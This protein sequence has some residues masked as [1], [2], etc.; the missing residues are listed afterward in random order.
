MSSKR[1]SERKDEQVMQ[2]Q[3]ATRVPQGFVFNTGVRAKKGVQRK[4]R[5]AATTAPSLSAPAFLTSKI[6][7]IRP[8]DKDIAGRFG[9]RLD[10]SYANVLACCKRFLKFVGTEFDFKPTAGL[11]L[12]QR[13]RELIEYFESK[14]EPL[15]L[16]LV[17][18]KK[19]PQGDETDTLQCVV[20]R[21]GK[22][23]E[24]TIVIL[25][26]APAKYLSPAGSQMYKRFMKFVSDST[27]IPLGI[28]EHSVNFFLDCIMNM[29]EEDDF[30]H[31]ED[32]EEK[33]KEKDPVLEKYKKDGE[34]WNLFDEINGLPS[35][36]P[37]D[38]Y[39]A[40]EVYL[41][42][43][44]VNETELVESMMEGIDVVKDAN[45]YRFEFNPD[46][47]G[48]EDEYG[49]DGYASSVF[50][51]AI[52]YSEHDGIS[53]ALLDNVNNEVYA[54]VMMTG[55][56]I[57]QWLSLKMKKADILDFMRCKDLC[58]SFDKWLRSFCKAT[59]KF[60]LYGKSKQDTE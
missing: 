25:Y 40:L 45:C 21:W 47:D 42:E 56:N 28:P 37:Q 20:Y 11:T 7:A 9:I 34:F 49:N 39:E 16:T 53:D 46:E 38:L 50:A 36:K 13:L 60:D 3:R 51:S 15:G 17:V 26:C 14:I 54:G 57:H 5:G 55:W 23:L 6:E 32:D 10:K 18:S 59:E 24:D 27:A 48:I 31:Y 22:E 8:T 52:L 1:Q 58:A 30:D 33:V 41:H 35:E 43:C 44:P 12:S 29:Y 4:G 2:T 19:F